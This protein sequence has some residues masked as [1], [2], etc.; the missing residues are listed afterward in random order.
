MNGIRLG[1]LFGIEI[2][3]NPSWVL[4]FLYLAF[5]FA[6]E[7]E[8]KNLGWSK[9]ITYTLGIVTSL[10]FFLSVL[11]HEFAHSLVAKAFKLPVQ[12]IS[13]H[14][15]GGVSQME[16]EPVRPRDEFLI[17]GAGP[18][19]SIL[20]GGILLLVSLFTFQSVPMVGIPARWLGEINIG[21]GLF[22]LIPG[23][24]IDGGRLLRALLWGATKDFRRATKIAARIGQG[25]A[26]LFIML[27][28]YQVMEGNFGGLW[29]GLI[30]FYLLGMAR[31]SYQQVELQYMLRGMKISSLSLE[32]LPQI[33]GK[34][35]IAD[36]L[37]NYIVGA[38]ERHF[39]IV[40]DNM[41][42]GL[43]S[44]NALTSLDEKVQSTQKLEDAMTA[45]NDL[46][47]LDPET[48]VIQALE[49]MS[50]LN[51]SQLPVVR[52]NELLGFIGRDTLLNCIRKRFEFGV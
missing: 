3:L 36:F 2:R 52:N 28:V 48:E 12:S 17:A 29:I 21:L 38:R 31:S 10:L 26:A 19:A 20:I 16:K 45:I 37:T 15:F 5:M 25:I 39:M 6:V 11:M 46:R 49:L 27:G 4:V 32:D 9:P 23:F 30:G 8:S 13:L 44:L 41:I 18:L 34:L 24:P 47:R 43:V 50:Q 35:N 1:K 22:N 42:R 7:F 33:S 14:L 51:T 40:D